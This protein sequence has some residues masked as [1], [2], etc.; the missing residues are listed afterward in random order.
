LKSK[1]VILLHLVYTSANYNLTLKPVQNLLK[2]TISM[3]FFC[4][5]WF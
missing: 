4:A 1:G 5:A 2:F 3:V